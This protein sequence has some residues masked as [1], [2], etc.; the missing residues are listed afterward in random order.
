MKRKR[1]AV[2]T[3][4]LAA[5][6]AT[7]MVILISECGYAQGS[8]DYYVATSGNDSNNGSKTS[9]WRTIS[10]AASVVAPGDT[11][12]V[13]PGV[14]NESVY[15][16]NSGTK[17][18]R[19]RF[20]S[21][22]PWG[23]K[24]TGDGRG[25]PAIQVRKGDYVDVVGFEVTNVNGYMGIETVASY[26]R[27]LGNLVH[28]VSGGCKLGKFTLGG[29]G[30]NLTYGHDV[31]VIGNVIHDI[32]DYLNPHGCEST[33]GIYVENAPSPNPGGYSTLAANNISYRNES[34]GITSWHCAT[35]M[36]LINNLIFENAKTGILVGANDRGCVNDH[37][38]VM[39]N[40]VIHNGWH[41]FCTLTGP[42]QCPIGNHSGDGG[43]QE[44]ASTGRNNRYAN[45]L[46]YGNLYKG[47]QD[48]NIHIS[49]GTQSNNIAGVDPQFVNYQPDGSGDYHLKSSSPAVDKGASMANVPSY[50]FDNYARPYGSGHDIGPYEWHPGNATGEL[51]SRATVQSVSPASEARALARIPQ[52]SDE[53]LRKFEGLFVSKA[54]AARINI[55]FE[56]GTLVATLLHEPGQPTV[57]LAPISATRFHFQGF[58]DDFIAEFN[59]SANR[60]EELTVERGKLPPVRL[61]RE[62]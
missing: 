16:N 28:D 61:S 48:D 12:H 58:P 13:M 55:R 33:Q 56:A 17:S 7:T 27:I 3:A 22:T 31:D 10:H 38:I 49:T 47:V 4:L 36:V 26:A 60:V 62:K 57:A 21:D 43:I 40:I 11:V 39:N 51:M 32:G 41:D 19:I 35:Q 2:I 5:L 20:I 42:S 15:L 8:K 37:T 6:L 54:P 9:P 24:V 1:T 53:E 18:Q 34:D 52:R 44:G 25:D 59:V 23:A 45:N 14:Y 46:S 50:D 30:I 29:A